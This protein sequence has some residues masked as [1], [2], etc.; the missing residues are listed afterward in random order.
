[1]GVEAGG[2]ERDGERGSEGG[3]EGS[4]LSHAAEA[5]KACRAPCSCGRHSA[6]SKMGGLGCVCGVRGVIK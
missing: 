2:T 1:M 3:T 4:R 6:R 5:Q